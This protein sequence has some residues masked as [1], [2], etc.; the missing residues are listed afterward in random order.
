MKKVK[1]H[2]DVEKALRKGGCKWEECKGSHRKAKL[3][4]GDVLVY[5]TH[6]EYGNGLAC[7]IAKALAAAGLLVVV[8]AA[9]CFVVGCLA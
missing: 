4:N 5:H 3:P 6:G 7:K 9:F 1:N 8:F 2:R